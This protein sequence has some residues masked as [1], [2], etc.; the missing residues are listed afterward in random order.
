MKKHNL[1][2][3]KLYSTII[4]MLTLAIFPMCVGENQVLKENAPNEL[5][6][7]CKFFCVYR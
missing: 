6:G 7:G 4:I 3:K 2:I 5:N 1:T